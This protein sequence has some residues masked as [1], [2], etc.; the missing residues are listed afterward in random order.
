MNFFIVY[1]YD[2]NYLKLVFL[3][4]CI[5]FI[6]KVGILFLLYIVFFFYGFN[7]IS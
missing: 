4:E 3:I 6:Y 2:Y 7:L 1:K 5:F